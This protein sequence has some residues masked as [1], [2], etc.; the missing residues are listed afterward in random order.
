[1]SKKAGKPRTEN[2]ESTPIGERLRS[3][4]V[5]VLGKSV[6]EVAKLLDTAPVHVS[7]IETGRRAPS[8]ELL[9]KIAEIYGMPLPE[10][11]AGFSR[12][13][14]VVAEVASES[15]VAAEKVP[16][17]LR[18]ARGFSAEQ[19]DQMIKQATTMN[20]GKEKQ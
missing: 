8:E 18:T 14:A 1:M 10:L 4:R 16:M 6:R 9:L 19:W 2:S 17:F 15:T 13:D 3:R 12:P 5:D 20:Q 7:D 11:R